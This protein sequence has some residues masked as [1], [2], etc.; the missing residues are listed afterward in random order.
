LDTVLVV[1][2][3]LFVI[4]L[5]MSHIVVAITRGVVRAKKPLKRTHRVLMW[6]SL[7]LVGVGLVLAVTSWL[8]INGSTP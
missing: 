7:G 2:V 4:G 3:G 5:V 8:L 1:G 6:S